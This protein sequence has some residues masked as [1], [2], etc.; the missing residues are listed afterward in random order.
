MVIPYELIH[1]DD[2]FPIIL[3]HDSEQR[4]Q[5]H[6]K[7]VEIEIDPAWI[8][9]FTLVN[10]LLDVLSAD[11]ATKELQAYASIDQVKGVESNTEVEKRLYEST[12]GADKVAPESN[13]VKN[14]SDSQGA[15]QNTKRCEVNQHL[16]VLIIGVHEEKEAHPDQWLEGELRGYD[17]V[18]ISN[19]AS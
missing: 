10:Q 7:V 5:R 9:I 15:Q 18:H 1:Q 17:P 19:G 8:N 11:L 13:L 3:P 6:H 4:V 2:G 14:R 12:Q 16:H